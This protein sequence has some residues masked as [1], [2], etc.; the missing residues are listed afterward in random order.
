MFLGQDYNILTVIFSIFMAFL[1]SYVS[2]D[3]A[4]RVNVNKENGLANIWK[5]GSG[6]SMGTGIWSMHFLGMLALKLPIT[7]GYT[8]N[9]TFL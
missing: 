4:K 5:I 8:F 9:F 6:F 1:A 3:L 7:I 2:I